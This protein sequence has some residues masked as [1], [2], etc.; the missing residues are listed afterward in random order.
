MAVTATAVRAQYPIEA[1]EVQAYTI[2][3]QSSESDG[4]LEWDETTLVYVE[5]QA[6]GRTGIGYTY[7]DIATAK[8]IA[9]LRTR[10]LRKDAMQIGALERHGQRYA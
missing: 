8:L 2:P 3:T 5:V 9:M 4:T 6:G 7:A 10:L 1:I